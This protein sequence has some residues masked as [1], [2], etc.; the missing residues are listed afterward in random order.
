MSK[1]QKY[2]HKKRVLYCS[3]LLLCN[4]IDIMF[5]RQHSSDTNRVCDF[6]DQSLVYHYTVN[7][8]TFRS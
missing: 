6:I 5:C 8:K 2:E 7:T 3:I 1:H 4:I